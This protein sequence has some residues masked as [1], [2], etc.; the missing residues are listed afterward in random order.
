M[1]EPVAVFE[2]GMGVRLALIS[3]PAV[4]GFSKPFP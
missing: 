3:Q 2:V 4:Q 1:S